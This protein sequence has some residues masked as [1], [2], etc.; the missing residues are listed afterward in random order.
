MVEPGAGMGAAF[1]WPLLL[2]LVLLAG[3]VLAAGLWLARRPA[4]PPA[5]LV[6]LREQLAGIAGRFEQMA[7][8]QAAQSGQTAERLQAQERALA[9]Q[10]GQVVRTVGEQ[11]TAQAQGTGERLQAQERALSAAMTTLTQRM[12]EQLSASAQQTLATV[13]QVTERLAVIDAAQAHIAALSQQVGGLAQILDD[14]QARGAFGETRLEDLV[15][16]ALPPDAYAFQHTLGNGA[17]ADCLLRLP[18]P[19]GPIAVDSK[20]P[21]EGW[22]AIRAAADEPAR[23]AAARQFDADVRK[24]VRDIA[25]KYLLPGETAD[26]ALMFVPSEAV[27]AALHAD[28]AAVVEEA[29]KRRVWI[30]SPTT[31]WALLNTVRA[32]MRDVEMRKEAAEVQRLVGLLVGDVKRLGERVDNLRRHFQQADKD[33]GEIE[34][35][36][37]NIVG[38]GERIRDVRFEAE[39]GS[40]PP[41]LPPSG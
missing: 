4:A 38:R 18:D 13:A 1:V 5:E 9:E 11:L 29:R 15:R 23:I 26:G 24:H 19:P 35:S 34:T 30:V 3:A 32:V 14:K 28:H 7:Q 17:R 25:E 39:P 27:Y 41:G 33:I 36:A 40:V 16:D 10:L 6:A 22:R 37:R 2:L 31:L 8:A 20:F 12:G 21:L